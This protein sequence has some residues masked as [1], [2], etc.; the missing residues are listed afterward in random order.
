MQRSSAQI[1]FDSFIF[2]WRRPFEQVQTALDI[3]KSFPHTEPVLRLDLAEGKQLASS[4]ID[5]ISLQ[6]RM[7][8]H[9]KQF[10]NPAWTPVE[11]GGMDAFVD[12]TNDK[13][14]LFTT[15][16]TPFGDGNWKRIPFADSLRTVMRAAPRS[17]ELREIRERADLACIRA[18]QG[19]LF[20]FNSRFPDP[21]EARASGFLPDSSK[22]FR[23]SRVN[24]KLS[25]LP[26]GK[27]ALIIDPV[28]PLILALFPPACELS[29]DHFDL[30]PTFFDQPSMVL[31]IRPR[32]VATLIE[33]LSKP[34][35][36]AISLMNG[37]L[38]HPQFSFR[39][40]WENGMFT[41]WNAPY[42]VL[43]YTDA[44]VDLM[45]RERRTDS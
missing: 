9:E 40:R 23:S 24:R 20:E 30:S 17:S 6:Q 3:L 35:L 2:A 37:T 33:L 41:L 29:L 44:L 45:R 38:H 28:S 19:D 43:W 34:G 25:R 10:F 13:L 27:P 12:L 36:P 42:Q 1:S 26:G 16:Y 32:G 14:P 18:A 39:F 15:L 11:T 5:W 7:S 21:L 8:A 22:L 31:Q 4:Q